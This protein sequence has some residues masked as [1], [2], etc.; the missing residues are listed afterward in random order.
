MVFVLTNFIEADWKAE[1]LTVRSSF[2]WPEAGRS[3]NKQAHNK[4]VMLLCY[5]PAVAN[6]C[7]WTRSPWPCIRRAEA[8]QVMRA[9]CCLRIE[10]PCHMR[11]HGNAWYMNRGA[12]LLLLYVVSTTLACNA[13]NS[14][15]TKK[16]LFSDRRS[17]T[18]ICL[19]TEDDDPPLLDSN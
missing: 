2:W 17:M 12:G 15:Y 6:S 13:M 11:L 19:A 1:R 10:A 8:D 14:W 7:T 4:L 9:V 16:L 3:Q 5:R 18:I